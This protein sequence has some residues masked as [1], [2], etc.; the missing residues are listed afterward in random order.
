MRNWLYINKIALIKSTI[1]RRV[2]DNYYYAQ[3]DNLINISFKKKHYLTDDDFKD[4]QAIQIPSERTIQNYRSNY[5]DIRDWLRREKAGNDKQTSTIN[6]DDVVFEVDLLKSQ[7]IDVEYILGLIF[8]HNKKSEDKSALVEE[9]RRLIRA[10]FG[11]R[12]KE[13]LLVDFINQTNLN[14]IL[15]KTEIMD[16]FYKFAQDKQ[17]RE[18]EA[19][20]ASENLSN[21][22]AKRYITTSLKRQ[23]ASEHG[24]ELNEILPKMSPLNPEY[25]PKKK[26]VFQ[27]IASFVEKFKGIGGKIE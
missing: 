19:L 26:S 9:V 12:A 7:E 3:K 18:A 17:Q 23:Y 6:W 1:Q 8:D 22:A 13:G 24:T 16:A 11:N 2:R 10:S 4:L 15:N 21:E 25:L 5:N 20:I 14:D 27:K